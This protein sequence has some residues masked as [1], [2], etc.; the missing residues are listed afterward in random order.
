MCILANKG[1][2][3]INSES[4]HNWLNWINDPDIRNQIELTSLTEAEH[5]T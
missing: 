4:V 2:G 3:L 5:F 1:V